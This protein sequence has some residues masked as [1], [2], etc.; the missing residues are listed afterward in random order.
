MH[1]FYGEFLYKFCIQLLIMGKQTFIISRMRKLSKEGLLRTDKRVGLM[2][3]IL[4]AMDTVKYN[5]FIIPFILLIHTRSGLVFILLFCSMSN[6][7]YAW[8]K[9]FKSKIQIM[10][11]DELSWFRKAQLLSAVC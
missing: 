8:E 4:A 11:D 6:R 1:F 5:N 9:S 10:R 3:E 7:Y 2:N